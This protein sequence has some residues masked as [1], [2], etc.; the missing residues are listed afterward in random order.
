ML[1]RLISRYNI[2]GDEEKD[3]D[4]S[5]L[6]DALSEK[7]IDNEVDLQTIVRYLL[8]K[9]DFLDWIEETYH[10]VEAEEE[11]CECCDCNEECY[12]QTNLFNAQAEILKET[13]EELKNLKKKYNNL[14][15][16]YKDMKGSL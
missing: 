16:K 2:Y 14:L 15:R 3:F 12:E 4:C 10:N 9:T 7:I 5:E 11:T 6:F 8:E 13:Q 1:D